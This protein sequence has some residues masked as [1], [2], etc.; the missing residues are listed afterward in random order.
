[1]KNM[2]GNNPFVFPSLRGRKPEAIS[3]NG[4]QKQQIATPASSGI[5]MTEFFGRLLP[6]WCKR[7]ACTIGEKNTGTSETLSPLV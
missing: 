6:Q 5:T 2:D 1:M 4:T 7:S 3:R